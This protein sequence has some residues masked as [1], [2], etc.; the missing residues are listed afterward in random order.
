MS[1]ITLTPEQA[2]P[3]IASNKNNSLT[4]YK[5]YRIRAFHKVASISVVEEPIS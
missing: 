1:D 2:A 5:C 3:R 4:S